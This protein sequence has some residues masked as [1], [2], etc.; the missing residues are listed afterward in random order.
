MA[1]ARTYTSS[2]NKNMIDEVQVRMDWSR[3]RCCLAMKKIAGRDVLLY[4]L[5]F[6]R[7]FTIHSYASETHLGGGL[8]VK[9]EIPSSL[10]WQVKTCTNKLY[11][12]RI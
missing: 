1:Q 9:M 6:N 2:S 7:R 10:L 11:D 3:E 8:L 4:Y 5:N 12:Y